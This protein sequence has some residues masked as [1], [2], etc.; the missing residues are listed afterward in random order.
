MRNL[1]LLFVVFLGLLSILIG[2]AKEEDC[3]DNATSNK[4]TRSYTFWMSNV[5]AC[6]R[7]DIEL[8][9]GTSNTG[10]PAS[11]EPTQCSSG[12]VTYFLVKGIYTWT[13]SSS[14]KTWSGS[15]TINKSNGDCQIFELVE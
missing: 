13:A 7:F 15:F 9:T 2:C 6:N 10:V 11:V 14:C 1:V 5:S 4:K 3:P 12:G 8:C